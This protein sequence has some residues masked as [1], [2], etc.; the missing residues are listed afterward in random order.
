MG[1][2]V[3]LGFGKIQTIVLPTVERFK[4]AVKILEN[5]MGREVRNT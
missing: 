3:I 1:T 5:L 4:L 2:A